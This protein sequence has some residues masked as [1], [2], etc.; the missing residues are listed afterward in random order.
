MV[1]SGT[2]LRVC[3][4]MSKCHM[5]CRTTSISQLFKNSKLILVFG[6]P[7]G[8][9][10]V[11]QCKSSLKLLKCAAKNVKNQVM[12]PEKAVSLQKS[13][14]NIST[15][16]IFGNNSRNRGYFSHIGGIFWTIRLVFR[17][18]QLYVTFLP[19]I[20][21]YPLMT[22]HENMKGFWWKLALRAVRL[23]GPC[24]VKLGEFQRFQFC[25]FYNA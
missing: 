7:C 12:L 3:Q 6:I 5:S 14:E 13:Q 23:N 1:L 20:L 22:W 10:A 25:F 19:L 8:T 16:T 24:I 2:I 21:L 15:S 11:Y 18:A 9:I 4:R 17:A